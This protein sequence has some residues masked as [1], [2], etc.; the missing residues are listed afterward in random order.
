LELHP[1]HQYRLKSAVAAD[2][3]RRASAIGRRVAAASISK[4]RFSKARFSKARFSKDW[5]APP[6]AL[7]FEVLSTTPKRTRPLSPFLM[8]R[9]QYTNALSILH[10]LAGLGLSVGLL[11]FVYWLVAAASGAAAYAQAQRCFA[12]PLVQVLLVG[13]SFAFFYHL[14]NGARHLVWDAG[15]GFEKKTA[16]LSGWL[17]FLGALLL[18]ACFWVARLHLHAGGMQ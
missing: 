8:Y 7:E 11:L 3:I 13:F 14:L 17:A 16:R 5:L 1:L 9:W 6:L 10:R 18:T 4:A 2:S 12:H 15:Y